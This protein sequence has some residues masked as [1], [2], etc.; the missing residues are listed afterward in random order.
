MIMWSRI[1]VQARLA[2]GLGALL[3]LFAAMVATAAM[4]LQRQ[5]QRTRAMVEVDYRRVQLATLA[6]DN[7]RGSIGRV[8][9]LASDSDA[10]RRG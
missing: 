2:V 1:G 8:L 7:A 6:L 3:L 10:T 9:Q 5:D 4:A